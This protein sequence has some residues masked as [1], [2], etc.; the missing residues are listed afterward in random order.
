M[1][2]ISLLGSVR[3][4]QVDTSYAN[5]LQSDRFLN[6]NEMSCPTWAGT[7][8]TGRR[9]C[10]DSYVTKSAGCNSS[11]DRVVVENGQR[12]Q[13]ME[14]INLSAN[15]IDGAMYSEDGGSVEMYGNTMPYAE[16]GYM[17]NQFNMPV[18]YNDCVNNKVPFNVCAN[19]KNNVTGNFGLQLNSD[20][21]STC[22]KDPYS[23]GMAQQYND[24]YYNMASSKNC[25]AY[26][27]NYSMAL[28]EQYKR[29]LQAVNRGFQSNALKTQ[30]GF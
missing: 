7:D 3:T 21:R 1:S 10:A 9:V 16:S 24:A 15:G 26:P 30:S 13:Y 4:C 8:S 11:E 29:G 18:N 23:F 28:Q 22:C 14:Y 12:P 17:N 27:Q 5:K 2:N 20:V 19:N 6:P 25:G